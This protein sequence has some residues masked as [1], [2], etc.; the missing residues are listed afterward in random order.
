MYFTLTFFCS[1]MENMLPLSETV[2]FLL[3]ITS[4]YIALFMKQYC[5][6]VTW[7]EFFYV[8]VFSN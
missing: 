6:Q 3:V 7:K 2:V 8:L 5:Q 4:A 1:A